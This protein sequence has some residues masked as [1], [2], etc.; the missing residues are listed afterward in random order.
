MNR[1]GLSVGVI[2]TNVQRDVAVKFESG[3][4]AFSS[5]LPP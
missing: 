3:E 2:L 1:L 4:A 5:C